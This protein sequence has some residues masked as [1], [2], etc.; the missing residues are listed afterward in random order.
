[1][2]TSQIAGIPVRNFEKLSPEQQQALEAAL[3]KPSPRLKKQISQDITQTSL[4]ELQAA[5]QQGVL[6]KRI[7]ALLKQAREQAQ[8]SG[9]TTAKRLKMNHAQLRKL[10]ESDINL[11]VSSLVRVAHELEFDVTIRLEPR[12]HG[13][14]LEAKL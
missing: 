6:Q 8:L 2:K 3:L 4:E 11:E 7:G 14:V 10:E 1:M 12:Q 9:R 5:V 13:N